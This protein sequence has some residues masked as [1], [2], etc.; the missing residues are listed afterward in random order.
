MNENEAI[1]P[2]ADTRATAEET[3]PIEGQTEITEPPPA[4]AEEATVPIEADRRPTRVRART[5]AAAFMPM[6][7]VGGWLAAWGAAAL[8]ASCLVTAGVSLGLG[9]GLA[10][11]QGIVED[12]FWPGF[13][14]VVIQAGAFLVG[15]YV[16]ARMARRNAMLHAGLA[17][18]VA[19]LATGADAVATTVRDSGGSVVGRIGLPHWTDTGL[20]RSAGLVGALAIF[21]LA[22][23]LGALIGG[24]LGAA[25]ERTAARRASL[26][27]DAPD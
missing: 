27:G 9:L 19:M 5:R 14:M 11:G 12:R 18:V 10:D 2:E 23:L 8:A 6:A 20:E 17:W 13:W 16:A 7:A 22:G 4:R 1:P 24:A 15:G 25:A 21:A 3:R 26:P